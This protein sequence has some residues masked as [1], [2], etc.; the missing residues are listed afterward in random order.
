MHWACLVSQEQTAALLAALLAALAA[1]VAQAV[2][3]VRVGLA[4]LIGKATLVLMGDEEVQPSKRALVEEWV[5]LAGLGDPAWAG[6]VHLD[7]LEAEAGLLD[8][9]AL[10]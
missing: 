8:P 10:Q 5:H 3:A 9:A 1:L 2:L 4:A 6:V 7:L